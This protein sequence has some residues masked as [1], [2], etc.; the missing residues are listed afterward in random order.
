MWEQ[1][2]VVQAPDAD[3]ARDRVTDSLS[4]WTPQS[5]T[6]A[7]A[8]LV[9]I[10]RGPDD[11]ALADQVAHA[12]SAVRQTVARS[13]RQEL[14]GRLHELKDRPVG[15]P[16]RPGWVVLDGRNPRSPR[17]TDLGT[18]REPRWVVTVNWPGQPPSLYHQT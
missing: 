7:V 2:W 1:W 13:N 5:E 12:L 4:V 10:Y 11:T 3:T 16:P 9:R 8:G 6:P 17:P 14:A 15:I 18:P